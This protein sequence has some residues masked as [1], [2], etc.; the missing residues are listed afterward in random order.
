MLTRIFGL[1]GTGKTTKM[2]EYLA[3]CVEE[4]KQSF[5][6]VPE[7]YALSAERTLI[8]KLGNPANMYIEVINFKRMCN[9]VFRECGGIVAKI[10]DEVTKQLA[11]SHVLSQISDNLHEYGV[12]AS[13]V[14]F[15]QK[16][17]TAVEQMH[18]ARIFPE[19]IEKV[20]ESVESE[21][22]KNKLHDISLSY[23]AY[24]DYT[25]NKLE[26][27]GD[28][29]DKLYETLCG[30][31]FFKGKT[32]FFDSFY[33]YTAQELA[34]IGKIISSADNVYATFLCDSEKMQ[35]A[36]FDRA[37]S[38]A[39]AFRHLA[40]KNGVQIQDV[41]LAD[42]LKYDSQ[43]LERI[44]KSFS[45]NALSGADETGEKHGIDVIKCENLYEES[46]CAVRIAA[47]LM[48]SGVKP[49]EIAIC[50]ASTEEY[51]GILDDEFEKANIPFSFDAHEDLSLSPVSALVSSA[52]E[53]ASTFGM[54]S[55]ID[56]IKTGLSGLEDSA[57][58][59][60]EIYMRTWKISGKRYFCE[61]WFMNP[62][63]FTEEEPDIEKLQRINASK[64]LIISC[65]EPFA[66]S[67]TCSKTAA[68]IARAI[69]TLT[70]DIA[71]IQG[72]AVLDDGAGGTYLDLLY[73]VLDSINE[74]IGDEQITPSR[75][76][77]LFKA[78][79]KNMK[80]G[81][82][83]EL[84]DQVRFSS[85]SLMRPDGVNYVIVLGANDGVFPKQR[86]TSGMFKD[87]ERKL[88]KS[89]GLEMAD[90]DEENSYD[91]IFLAYCALCSAKKGAYVTYRQKGLSDETMYKSV[92][93]SILEKMFGDGINTE[94]SHENLLDSALSDELLFDHYMTM[95]ESVEKAT[96]EAYFNEKEQYRERIKAALVSDFSDTPLDSKVLECLFGER[97]VSSYSRIEKYRECPF[98]YFCT[99][100]LKLSPEPK[101]SL[102]APEIGNTVHKILEELVPVFS[103]MNSDGEEI[104]VDF[105]KKTVKEKLSEILER[106]MHG[107]GSAVT[108]RFEYMFSRLEHSVN[109]LCIEL[110]SELKESKFVPVDFELKL[111]YDGDVPPV[112]TNLQDG[113]KL[114]IVGAIDRVDVYKDERTGQSWIRITDYKTGSK[115]FK[116]EDAREGFNLQMLLY[117]YS[118]TKN[119][120]EKYGE[121]KPAGVIYR[122][123]LPPVN[124][125][126]S[127]EKASDAEYEEA[128]SVSTVSGLVVS[129]E[130]VLFAMEPA[131]GKKG[132]YIPY[133][134]SAG[135]VKGVMPYDELAE[136]LEDAVNKA[137]ELASEIAMG[138][139]NMH[140]VKDGKRDACMF[141]DY[142]DICR[143][144]CDV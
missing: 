133:S 83:P 75:F 37:T 126:I 40:E 54:Q 144:S 78:C 43:A 93:V 36:S 81:K 132:R 121:M 89:L 125:R 13:D 94:F 137:A 25:E 12:V 33:G 127:F 57:A 28:L 65:L 110:A 73:R 109:S 21:N 23:E 44:A 24:H 55:I 15:A 67:L 136:L 143:Y 8:E 123:V 27:P 97:M 35:D 66:V 53:A 118:L 113:R 138:K 82:I 98:K 18:M 63:G 90:T 20:L 59:E 99:Y 131:L 87:S 41:V 116:V 117:L 104:T 129:D 79:V 140:P 72:K 85:V 108:K 84:I 71:K 10:P 70:K 58:D 51:E 135:N 16:M 39:K 88:L 115:E 112:E 106:F 3:K 14:S 62:D 7:Q 9:R 32:V 100:T 22:L 64:Q 120:T 139:K 77:E 50:A 49:R 96:L 74:T 122:M 91:Q 31:D 6:V 29:L 124:D 134:E 48:L 19:D 11:M 95:E 80:S 68:Q 26:F 141:C 102:G 2:Y 105:I 60:L 101:A 76:N 38:A 47:E 130:D 103:K 1:H 61:E 107:S 56:Y 34:I 114:A 142:K 92:I 4:K 52:F 128:E 42:A 69:Y 30:F 111:S 45:L 46:E 86:D 5:V 17:L 119:R